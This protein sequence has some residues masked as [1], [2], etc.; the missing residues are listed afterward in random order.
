MECSH[1]QGEVVGPGSLCLFADTYSFEQIRGFL[2]DEE[3]DRLIELGHE[4][5]TEEH[6]DEWRTRQY[7]PNDIPS[8][9]S[10]SLPMTDCCV[11]ADRSAYATV[12]FKQSA[13]ASTVLLRDIEDRI[14]RLT[15]I[16]PDPL[17]GKRVSGIGV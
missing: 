10:L 5:L 6:G 17:E 3:A 12:F 15:M 14:A 1:F 9:K 13:Y 8:V 11:Y 16:R 2:T 4:Q 7:A